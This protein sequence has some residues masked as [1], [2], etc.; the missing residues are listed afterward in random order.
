M[1]RWRLEARGDAGRP[2][3]PQIAFWLVVLTAAL[4]AGAG[5]GTC[6]VLV[7]HDAADGDAAASGE[8]DLIV[9]KDI[10]SVLQPILKLSQGTRPFLH[11]IDQTTAP[12]GTGYKGLCRRD[13][14]RLRYSPTEDTGPFPNRKLRPYSVEAKAQFALRGSLPIVWQWTHPFPAVP[15]WE[16]DCGRLNDNAAVDWFSAPRSDREA[17]PGT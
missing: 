17:A 10:L 15:A 13:V 7:T 3:R 1:R 5:L 8:A 9:K 12:F 16:A 2:G 11:N 14:V 4:A 6:R